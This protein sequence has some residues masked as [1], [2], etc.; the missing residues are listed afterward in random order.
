MSDAELPIALRFLLASRRCELENLQN[1][2]RICGLGTRISQLVHDLQNERDYSC[3]YLGGPDKQHLDILESLSS[4]S[5]KSEQHLR[6]GLNGA[7]EDNSFW[8]TRLLNRIAHALHAL[9]EL[10]RLRQQIS[11]Q[12]LDSA[13][14]TEVFTRI[15]SN[16]LAV[17]FEATDMALTSEITQALVAF[18]NFMQGK[19]LSGQERAIG[20]VAISNGFFNDQQQNKIQDLQ[21]KQGQCLSI[22][23]NYANPAICRQWQEILKTDIFQQLMQLRLVAQRTSVVNPVDSSFGSIWFDTFTHYIDAMKAIESLL[24]ENL[25]L[26]CRQRMKKA[27]SDLSNRRRLADQLV[28]QKD[29][30]Q[31]ILFGIQSHTLDS[32]LADIGTQTNNTL[33]KHL[34][35]QT[36]RLKALSDELEQARS[37]LEQ[38]QKADRAKHLLMKFNQLNEPAAHEKLLRSSMESGK[39][40]TQIIEDILPPDSA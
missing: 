37:A 1:L 20:V 15:I 12:I 38:R 16:L 22:F 28:L 10:P 32:P 2:L 8:R 6:Q 3:L 24:V 31:A 18:F 35:E 25:L 14:T 40:L 36:L 7:E 19:E 34:H 9:D 29:H 27:Q 11:E 4:Y 30:H 23:I 33:L 5:I 13:I 39:P 21:H 17:V 26:L